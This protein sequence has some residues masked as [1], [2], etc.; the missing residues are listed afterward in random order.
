[1]P[2]AWRAICAEIPDPG[3]GLAE[4]AFAYD[5]ET[6]KARELGRDVE[7]QYGKLAPTEIPGSLDLLYMVGDVLH[8]DDYKTGRSEV[9][10]EFRRSKTRYM[11]L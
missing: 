9:P 10:P 1:M 4:V 11:L 2:E 3:Q 7:R 6:G 5:V 8:I